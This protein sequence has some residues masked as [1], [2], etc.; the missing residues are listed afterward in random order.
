MMQYFGFFFF[1]F[2]P[3]S[4]E[5]G[6]CKDLA[7]DTARTPTQ[8]DYRDIPYSMASCSARK[9]GGREEKRGEC[10]EQ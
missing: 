2:C 5:L 7:E 10:S 1:C 8:T 6:A 4:E 3:A 9:A